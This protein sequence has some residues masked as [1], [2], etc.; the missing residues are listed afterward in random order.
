MTTGEL[1]ALARRDMQADPAYRDCVLEIQYNLPVLANRD[2]HLELNICKHLL[3]KNGQIKRRR[4]SPY[5]LNYLQTIGC[6]VTRE[7]FDTSIVIPTAASIDKLRQW[8]QELTDI[9]KKRAEAKQQ[10]EEEKLAREILRRDLNGLMQQMWNAFVQRPAGTDT[11]RVVGN[12]PS[13]K[14]EMLDSFHIKLVDERNGEQVFEAGVAFGADCVIAHAKAN[15]QPKQYFG[16]C[17]TC[18][19]PVERGHDCE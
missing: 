7:G 3:L 19:Q 1:Y 10:V 15:P 6:S 8:Q 14:Q 17:P 4:V 12:Y 5:T 18:H 9:R 11:V 2:A 16:T 13:M